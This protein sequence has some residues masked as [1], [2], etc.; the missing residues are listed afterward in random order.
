MKMIRRDNL[1][2]W[3]GGYRQ[4]GLYHIV[5]FFEYPANSWDRAV[6]DRVAHRFMS[7]R[8]NDSDSVNSEQGV[9][10]EGMSS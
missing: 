9:S 3:S 5:A 1:W 4:G 7:Y 6:N 10:T 2:C 8:R